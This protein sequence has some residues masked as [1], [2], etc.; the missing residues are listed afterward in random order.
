MG[1][2]TDTAIPVSV[3]FAIPGIFS[4]VPATQSNPLDGSTGS[5]LNA[6]ADTTM[7]KTSVTG[8]SGKQ[9]GFFSTFASAAASYGRGALTQKG[10]SNFPSG[11]NVPGATKLT[12]PAGQADWIASSDNAYIRRVE[13][14]GGQSVQPALTPS[15]QDPIAHS[16]PFIPV[17]AAGGGLVV[18]ALILGCTRKDRILLIADG[19]VDWWRRAVHV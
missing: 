11:V 6:A 19:D 15:D 4:A 14:L 16:S 7:M 3:Q 12:P 1:A 5:A 10:T 8:T 2:A 17:I 18:L 9:R 13:A